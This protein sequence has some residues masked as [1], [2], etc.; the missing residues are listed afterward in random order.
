MRL[1]EMLGKSI[2]SADAGERVGRVDD[3]L[4]DKRNRHVVVIRPEFAGTR[5]E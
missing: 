1:S 2:V 5:Q 3:V 4:L